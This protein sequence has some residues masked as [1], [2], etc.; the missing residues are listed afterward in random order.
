MLGLR[1]SVIAVEFGDELSEAIHTFL[2]VN[3]DL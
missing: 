3:E 2:M 1:Q